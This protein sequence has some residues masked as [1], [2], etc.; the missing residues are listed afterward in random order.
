MLSS[1]ARVECRCCRKLFAVGN[2]ALHLGNCSLVRVDGRPSSL[3]KPVPAQFK[4]KVKCASKT[5]KRCENGYEFLPIPADQMISNPKTMWPKKLKS[6]DRYSETLIEGAGTAKLLAAE[7]ETASSFMSTRLHSATSRQPIRKCVEDVERGISEIG[8][9]IRGGFGR[10][11]E[12]G[13]SE[14]FVSIPNSTLRSLPHFL[15]GRD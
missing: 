2:F 12:V 8:Q 13:V 5:V 3:D 15:K 7:L 10:E 4:R 14:G 9:E 1:A 6:I 11:K